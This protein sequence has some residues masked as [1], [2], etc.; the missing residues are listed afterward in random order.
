MKKILAIA[1]LSFVIT[2]CEPN[3]TDNSNAAKPVST[4]ASTPVPTPEA[5]PAAKVELKAGDKVKVTMNGSSMEA[6][7]VSVDLKTGKA[8]VK[9]QGQKEDKTVAI[10]DIVKQ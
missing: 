1:L 4:P 7:I 8:T 10:S 5:S 9:I 2:A 3:T 6:T